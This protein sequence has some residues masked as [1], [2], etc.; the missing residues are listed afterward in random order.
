[1]SSNIIIYD[2]DTK[3]VKRYWEGMDESTVSLEPCKLINPDISAV[4]GHHHSLWKV[5]VAT[6]SA[7][8]REMGERDRSAEDASC[9]GL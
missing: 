5:D 7:V 3:N 8:L 2:K 1:M 9:P 6:N 4:M